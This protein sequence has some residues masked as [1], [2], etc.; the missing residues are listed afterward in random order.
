MAKQKTTLGKVGAAIAGAAVT[1]V[2]AADEHVVHPVGEALGL[3]DEKKPAGKKPA[4]KKPAA[5][6]PAPAAAT[7]P[8]PAAPKTSKQ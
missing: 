6:A 3:M 1:A 7:P 4:T 8:V 5:K 2:H